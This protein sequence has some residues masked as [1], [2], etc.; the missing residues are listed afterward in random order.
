RRF[1]EIAR[2]DR[3][4]T[5]AAEHPQADVLAFGAL[6]ILELAEAYLDAFGG[7][8]DVDDVGRVGPRRP[9]AVVQGLGPVAGG[10]GTQHGNRSP[11]PRSARTQG[12]LTVRGRAAQSGGVREAAGPHAGRGIQENSRASSMNVPVIRNGSP[13]A[14][15]HSSNWSGR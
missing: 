10:I 12:A 1:A 4:R 13:I 8:A 9:R 15:T 3:G 14:R 7:I 6:D 5:A 11:F 2:A